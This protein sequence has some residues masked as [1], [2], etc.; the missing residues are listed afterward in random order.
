MRRRESDLRVKGL[1]LRARFVLAM[2][3]ALT[4]VMLAACYVLHAT[5]TRI[6]QNVQTDTISAAVRF[7]QE[8]RPYELETPGWMHETGVEVFPFNYPSD[9]R[10][11]LYAYGPM[12]PGVAGEA[13]ELLVPEGKRVGDDLLKMIAVIMVVVVLV[14]AGVALWVA[15]EVSAPVHEL[16]DDVRQIAKGDLR[17]QTTAVGGGEIELLARAIDR[18]TADLEVAQEAQ[19]ELS[20]RQREREVAVGV[21]EALLPLATPLV[22]GYD[23]GAAFLG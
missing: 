10:G 23:V 6:A 5:A 1:G 14:G 21:R 9:R 8:A 18:M 22:D 16:I 13:F 15:G 11:T 4:L 7:T 20:V 17:H 12:R 3:A 19:V 2:T